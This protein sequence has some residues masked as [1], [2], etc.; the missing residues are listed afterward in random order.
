MANNINSTAKSGLG[1]ALIVDGQQF[2]AAWR[3]DAAN[4][5]RNTLDASHAQTTNFRATILDE[6]AEEM[7]VSG[8]FLFD[9]KLTELTELMTSDGVNQIRDIYVMLPKSSDAQGVTTENGYIHM[10]QGRLG[11]GTLNLAYDDIM[12]ADFTAASGESEVIIV[13]QKVVAGNVPTATTFS[14][15][16]LS[17]TVEDDIVATLNYPTGLSH[18]PAIYFDLGGADVS[19]FYLEGKFIKANSTVTTGVKALT[20]S[21]AGYRAWAEEDT[22]SHLTGEVVGFTLT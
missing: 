19:E 7:T 16:N 14:T 11:L 3:P 15:S 5:T 13:E 20:V 6:L 17:G 21:V 8:S 4:F 22:G 9:P 2:P 18:G 1:A 12:E 10:S